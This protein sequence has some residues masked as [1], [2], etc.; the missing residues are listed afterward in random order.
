[1][2][3]TEPNEGRPEVAAAS[4]MSAGLDVVRS[5]IECCHSWEP[6]AT[7]LGNVRAGDAANALVSLIADVHE[8]NV[9]ATRIDELESR[10]LTIGSIAHAHSTGPAVHDEYWNIRN[11]AYELL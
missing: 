2:E 7:I 10:L 6:D 11:L 8:H 5:I 1:M 9:M 4:E 3:I